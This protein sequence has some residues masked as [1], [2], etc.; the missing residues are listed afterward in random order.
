MNIVIVGGGTAGSM[1]ALFCQRFFPQDKI[2]LIDSSDIGIIGVGE[3]TTPSI[4]EILDFLG[5]SIND[6][7]NHC[8]ATIKNS[9]RFTNWNGNGEIYHHGF[10]A[11]P[12]LDILVGS[13]KSYFSDHY[14]PWPAHKS[15]L[16]INELAK[17][18]TLDDIHFGARLSYLNKVPWVAGEDKILKHRARVGL[19]FDARKVANYFKNLCIK[20]GIELI[21]N[22]VV[23]AIKDDNGNISKL[24][25]DSGQCI[26]T[27]F[28]FD[29]TGFARLFVKKIY[30]AE[31]NS[32]SNFLPVKKAIPFFIPRF[33]NT[34]TFT[35]A[36]AMSS[37]W[38]W[39]TPVDGRFG[40]GYVFDSDYINQDQAYQ[41]VS[42][43][44]GFDPEVTR[45]LSFESGYFKSPWNKN[46]LAVGL[47]SGFLEPLEATSIWITVISLNLFVEHIAGF[48][49]RDSKAIKEYN[50]EFTRSI[51]SILALVQFHY[52][53][54]RADSK[55]WIEF[56]E[57]NQQCDTLRE[58]ID[59]YSY[60]LPS[61]IESY[62]YN[63]FPAFSWYAVGA[64]IKFFDRDV[65]IK[66]YNCYNIQRS[67]FNETKNKFN[68]NLENTVNQCLD[69]DNFLNYLRY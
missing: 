67:L 18:N 28:I 32:F 68:E 30:D 4:I 24:Q 51:N 65:I 41:E 13:H 9:T 14:M 35:E 52:F 42:N 23:D 55:F 44:L 47:S 12:D 3:S 34:P 26:D 21:D 27:D 6:M 5:I 43:L 59:L 15:F 10:N 53:V 66:E 25:L 64:G 45:C 48:T 29:C 60:R 7:V 40:C 17:G 58:I 8:G 31:F 20:R 69:H 37:G 33:G 11:D 49:H 54:K 38:V 1:S 39:K 46:T 56:R 50:K 63:S 57:K 16:A 22:K 36:I 61:G 62:T 19:H 2:C